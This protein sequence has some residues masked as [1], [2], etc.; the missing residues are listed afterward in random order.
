M[1]YWWQ[2]LKPQHIPFRFSASHKCPPR[3]VTFVSTSNGLASM[4]QQ[5]LLFGHMDHCPVPISWGICMT[6]Y[7]SLITR[8]NIFFC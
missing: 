3:S 2:V 4:S 6:L 8:C 7:I 5:R 1:G